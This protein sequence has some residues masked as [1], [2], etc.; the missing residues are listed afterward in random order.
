MDAHAVINVANNRARHRTTNGDNTMTMSL[1]ASLLPPPH[2]ITNIMV[3]RY[4]LIG[5]LWIFPNT[6]TPDPVDLGTN[7]TYLHA[8]M[9]K[10]NSSYVKIFESSHP[11][12]ACILPTSRPEILNCYPHCSMIQV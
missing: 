10:I 11:L 2:N 1:F 9:S 12:L 3:G 8:Q 7:S 5:G 6:K 4:Q